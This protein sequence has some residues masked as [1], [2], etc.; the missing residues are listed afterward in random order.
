[1]EERGVGKRLPRSESS[2]RTVTINMKSIGNGM[3]PSGAHRPGRKQRWRKTTRRKF[4]LSVAKTV[5]AGSLVALDVSRFA[6]AA[7][8]GVIR[9]GLIGCGGRGT[10]AAR[11]ALAAGKDVKLVAMADVI[12]QKVGSSLDQ[13]KKS[14]IA[15]QLDVPGERQFSGFDS[16]QHLLSVGL[17][18]VL[19]ATPPGF[20]AL[21]VEAAVRAGLH[22]FLE[23]PVAVD[24]PGVRQ[25]R[26]TAEVA[27][28]NGLSVIVG[29]QEHFDSSYQQFLA[30]L[31]N[32]AIGTIK[33]LN[34]VI[35]W[36]DLP[37]R[38]TRASVDKQLRRPSTEMEFQIRN[39][40]PFSWLSGDMIVETL[41][42]HIDTCLAAVGSLPQ[43]VQGTA[44]RREHP[45]S[46]YGN[47]SDFL[48]A[49]YIFADGIELQAEISALLDNSAAWQASLEGEEGIATA[50]GKIV[51]RQGQVIWT[52]SGPKPDPYQEEMNQWC[53]SI[54]N[55]KPLN[56]LASAADSTLVAIMGRTAAYT[57]REVSWAEI[58][59]GN[60]ALFTHNPKSFQD[61]PPALPDKFGDY[62]FPPLGL[63]DGA[64]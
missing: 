19:V 4:I 45:G 34:A 57:G 15:D 3:L 62:R 55:G 51:G 61:A 20:H 54:R 21:H 17:D 31:S 30:E 49:R 42:H 47:I 36:T 33:K 27:T 12:E 60:E 58:Q 28:Q 40:F 13:L 16:F 10:G 6:H 22:C 43:H 46:D 26:A 59:R 2:Q 1:M 50:P 9:L 18:A 39:W 14:R 56:T 8:S 38:T 48:T 53:A 23:K 32:G 64:A 52:Y 63:P 11:N 44:E 35:R 5:A 25:V 7:G 29:F 24:A 37:R 41:V